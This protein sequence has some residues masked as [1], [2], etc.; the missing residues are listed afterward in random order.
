M[1]GIRGRNT[2]PEMY[3]RRYLHGIGLRYRLHVKLLSS[4]PDLVFPRF[5]TIIFV[6]GCFWHRHDG[7]KF[8]TTP[9]SNHEFW[10]AKFSENVIRD[11]RNVDQLLNNGWRVVIIWECGLKNPELTRKLAWLPKLITH[12]RKVLV[13]WPRTGATKNG[14]RKRSQKFPEDH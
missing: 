3:V 1:S 10:T 8:A 14:S 9:S 2:K 7:C 12:G 13:E 11:K 6:H 4:T 5:K